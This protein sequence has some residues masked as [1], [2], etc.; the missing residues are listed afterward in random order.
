[1]RRDLI[2]RGYVSEPDLNLFTQTDDI[3]VA[4]EEIAKFYVN[5]DSMRFTG[6][7]K[8]VFRLREV[9]DDA[10]L[11][12]LSQ[13]FSDIITSGGIERAEPTASEVADDDALDMQRIALRF[14]R[15]SYGRLRTLIDELNRL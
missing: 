3:N 10:T 6:S 11:V 13:E 1:V 8:L 5:Y 4:A 12:R 14:D 15:M 2:G 7:G 9:P